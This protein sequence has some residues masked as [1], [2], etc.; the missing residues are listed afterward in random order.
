MVNTK[1]FFPFISLAASA[2][3][4]RRQVDGQVY[5]EGG[6]QPNTNDC[7]SAANLIGRG[8]SYD[9]VAEFW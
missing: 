7:V 1:L 3:V 9:A 4:E 2:A 5:C 8:G 6:A